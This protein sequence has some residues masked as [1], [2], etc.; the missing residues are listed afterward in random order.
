VRRFFGGLLIA[1]GGL[2]LAGS[3]LC[4]VLAV[5]SGV[6]E[7]DLALALQ[8]ALGFGGPV[9]LVGG[10]LFWGGRVLWRG[11]SPAHSQQSTP[12]DNDK[13]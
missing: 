4:A 6:V 2:M 13:V 7:N 9:A 8:I 1:I 12:R 5:G 3:G 10:A 11:P